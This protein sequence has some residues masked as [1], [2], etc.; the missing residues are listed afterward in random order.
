MVK[1]STHERPVLGSSYLWFRFENKAGVVKAVS[2]VL[3][4]PTFSNF[5][6]SETEGDT[7]ENHEIKSL[8]L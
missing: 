2:K 8:D 1:H 6:N 7:T 5:H 4:A 3:T